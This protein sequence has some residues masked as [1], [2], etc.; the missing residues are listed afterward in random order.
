MERQIRS[1]TGGI[2]ELKSPT[3]ILGLR[4]SLE[5]SSSDSSLSSQNRESDF[6]VDFVDDSVKVAD[7][8]SVTDVGQWTVLPLHRTV[9]EFLWQPDNLT[10]VITAQISSKRRKPCG[11]GHLYILS[12]CQTWLR[13]PSHQEAEMRMF[14]DEDIVMDVAYHSHWIERMEEGKRSYPWPEMQYHQLLDGIDAQLCARSGYKD[15]WPYFWAQSTCSREIEK[16]WR[17]DF[18]AFA[19][20]FDM[21]LLVERRIKEGALDVNREYGLP[22]LH[23]SVVCFDHSPRRLRPAMTKLLLDHGAAAS[24]TYRILD[25]CKPI[26]S[27]AFLI[28]YCKKIRNQAD[29]DDV[30]QV[31]RMLVRQG[32]NPNSKLGEPKRIYTSSGERVGEPVLLLVAKLGLPPYNLLVILKELITHGADPNAQN[33][34]EETLLGILFTSGVALHFDGWLWLL[35]HGAR[36]TTRIVRFLYSKKYSEHALRDPTYRKQHYYNLRARLAALEYN[37]SW[38]ITIFRRQYWLNRIDDWLSWP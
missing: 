10:V 28:Y 26:D 30:E 13:L 15:C 37:P 3:T 21:P 19:V 9:L 18:V 23:F 33:G 24:R 11:D 34:D 22:L 16:E 32:A 20:L 12:A 4:R 35:D 17:F 25:E 27:L 2:L 14:S 1:Y 29:A 6:V 8:E 31:V 36:I 38:R 7:S 5:P